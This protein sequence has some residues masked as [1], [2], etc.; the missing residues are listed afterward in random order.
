M[1][2]KISQMDRASALTKDDLFVISR[3]SGNVNAN[4]AVSG[5]Q[6]GAYVKTLNNGS[7][8]G[9][10]EKSLDEFTFADSGVY[11]WQGTPYLTGMPSA[12]MLEVMSYVA[13][14]EAS[15]E[16]PAIFERLTAGGECF[17]RSKLGGMWSSWGVLSNK[18]GNIIFSGVSN[19]S[20]VVFPV[21]FSVAPVVTLTPVNGTPNDTV[22]V[23]NIATVD[24]NKFTVARY[25]CALGEYEE[26]ETIQTTEQS[27]TT[28]NK[29]YTRVLSGY[30]WSAGSFSYYW[31]ATLDG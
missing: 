3:G 8:Y 25:Q 11:Y 26:Q 1:G 20:E 24:T 22:N 4:Y 6:V 23:I 13:P 28:T 12:A 29:T 27:G 2:I 10:T 18:N 5:Q 30:Q 14:D 17:V 21:P 9:S 19:A 7:F 15:G 16:E 31:T